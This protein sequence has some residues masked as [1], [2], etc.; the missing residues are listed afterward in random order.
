MELSL[1]WPWYSRIR[2]AFR[3]SIK[4]DRESA[5]LIASIVGERLVG[6]K[7]IESLVRGKDVFVFGAGPSLEEDVKILSKFKEH[8]IF[9]AADGASHVL[10]ANRLDAELVVTDLD[11]IRKSIPFK[12]AIYVVH[13]HGD[14]IELLREVVPK[15]KMVHPTTQAE[16]IEDVY[17]YGGFTDGDRACFLAEEMGARRIILAGMDLG[18]KI[19]KYSG[20]SNNR[21]TIKKLRY[22]KK[23]LSFL[24][25]FSKSELLNATSGGEEIP[26]FRRIQLKELEILLKA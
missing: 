20:G 18:K 4:K 5:K 16:P 6:R 15:L 26:G 22:A 24:S 7:V 1:W 2:R 11:G 3:F 13:A 9:M 19:G 10:V 12:D 14:N 17:N 25:T 8:A 21:F 23:L